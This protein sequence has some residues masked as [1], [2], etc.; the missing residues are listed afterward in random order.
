MN[1]VH[2]A[3]LWRWSGS[4]SFSKV[5]TSF[6]GQKCKSSTS[7]WWK[8]QRS[9]FFAIFEPLTGIKPLPNHFY[10]VEEVLS[11]D[12]LGHI[13]KSG[14]RNEYFTSTSQN[15]VDL[16]DLHILKIGFKIVLG[17]VS[18]NFPQHFPQ[19][20]PQHFHKISHRISSKISHSISPKIFHRI[21]H[22]ISCKISQA[23]CWLAIFPS[24]IPNAKF[25][26]IT[27][28]LK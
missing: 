20:L 4:M 22:K 15:E 3:T 12:L 1:L 6:R 25:P 14:F 23:K 8:L 10:L 13:W 24:P 26:P 19:E 17:I 21:S 11:L 7:R 27:A 9:V 28:F 18:E 5:M 16:D 2:I